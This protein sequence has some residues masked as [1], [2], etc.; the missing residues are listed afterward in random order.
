HANRGHFILSYFRFR[1]RFNSNHVWEHVI[2]RMKYIELMVG[3]FMVLG[4][5]AI[6]TMAL[7]VSGLSG[8]S[9]GPTYTLK[10]RFENLGGL[11]ERAKV[12]MGGVTIG[13]VTKV[14]LDP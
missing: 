5:V 14:Y 6:V 8:E 2:M 3:A 1:L 12:S 7:R 13:R 10:A 11:T 9:Y 4:I